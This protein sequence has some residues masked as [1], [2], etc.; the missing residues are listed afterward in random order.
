MPIGTVTEWNGANGWIDSTGALVCFTT[1]SLS[2]LQPGDVHVGLRV[3]FERDDGEAPRGRNVRRLQLDFGVVKKNMQELVDWVTAELDQQR[4]AGGCCQQGEWGELIGTADGLTGE[5][6]LFYVLL[7][8]HFAAPATARDFYTRL[9]WKSLLATSTTDLTHFCQ[10]FFQGYAF[11]GDHRRHFRCMKT[12]QKIEY[13]VKV[14]EAYKA[15]MLVPTYGSQTS[16]FETTGHP[17]FETLY[18]RMQQIE[19][20][21]RRLPRFDHLE[22]LARTHNYY[23]VPARF[24]ADEDEGGPRDGL[25]LLVLDL[26]LRHTPGLKEYLVRE[27]P[28]EWNGAPE[29]EAKYHMPG[30]ARL[31][32]VLKVLEIWTIDQVRLRLPPRHQNAPAY[33]FELESCLCNWQKGQ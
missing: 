32:D 20:F 12:D 24:F 15:A 30:R 29:I 4:H 17:T 8:T 13:T 23:I 16:F 9:N 27:F 25:T 2:V 22:R 6:K 33:V 21:E 18:N 26:R 10:G 5:E 11:I 1:S 14:L 7:A 3:A 31:E 28:A 19:F